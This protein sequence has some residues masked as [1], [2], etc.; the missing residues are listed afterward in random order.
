M[1]FGLVTW[2]QNLS[3]QLR[4]NLHG[5]GLGNRR[6]RRHRRQRPRTLVLEMCE[7]REV[8]SLMS[9]WQNEANLYDVNADNDVTP[10]DALIVS[11]EINSIREGTLPA[12][13]SPTADGTA[14]YVDADGDQYLTTYDYDLVAA[15]VPSSSGSGSGE[16]DSWGS[17]FG[18]DSGSGSGW[19]DDSDSG[20]GSGEDSG[21]GSG[22][23]SGDSSGSGSDPAPVLT[24]S[25]SPADVNEGDTATIFGM[26]ENVSS[27]WFECPD[28]AYSVNLE[29]I[30]G[31]WSIGDFGFGDDLPAGS[32]VDPI[33]VRIS[34]Y[35]S[36]G[37]LRTAS[38]TVTVHD[39]PPMSIVT[40]PMAVPADPGE[41]Y[42]LQIE[43]SATPPAIDEGQSVALKVEVTE[44]TCSKDYGWVTVDWGDGTSAYTS[45][46]LDFREGSMEPLVLTHQYLDDN[47]TATP[48][49]TYTITITAADQDGLSATDTRTV[50]VNNVAPAV[51]ID[52]IEVLDAV[53]STDP[54]TG[55]STY[56]NLGQLDESEGFK[57]FGTVT[58][59]GVLDEQTVTLRMD[60][61]FDGYTDDSQETV[62]PAVTPHPYAPGRWTFEY[63]VGEV[64]DDGAT[65]DAAGN[66]VWGNETAFDN[67]TVHAEVID[68]DTGTGPDER[69]VT[70]YNVLP[71]FLEPGPELSYVFDEDAFLLGIAVHG[72]VTDHGVNDE[73]RVTVFWGDGITQ[74]VPLDSTGGFHAERN[75]TSEQDILAYELGP[76][77]VYAED[78]DT[79]VVMVRLEVP[80]VN[81]TI[82]DGQNGPG[83]PEKGPNSEVARGAVTVG[84]LNDSDGD[85][86]S[87]VADTVVDGALFTHKEVD[88]MKLEIDKPVPYDPTN[89]AVLT[90][91]GSAK[92]WSEST[93]ATELD[94]ASEPIEWQP[95]ET[96]KVV[97][98]EAV[99]PST[100]LRDIG[101]QLKYDGVLDIVKAT[102]V[103][104]RR[105]AYEASVKSAAD[106]LS[107]PRFSPIQTELPHAGVATILAQL[108]GT[109]LTPIT[110]EHVSNAILFRFTVEPPGVAKLSGV[111]F[112]VTRRKEQRTWF[113]GPD[114]TV[115]TSEFYP[116][117][118]DFPAWH[119]DAA[120]D[121]TPEAGEVDESFYPD[122]RDDMFS[123]DGPGVNGVPQ[124]RE[125][126]VVR[127]LNFQEFVRVRFDG[128]DPAGGEVSGLLDGSRCSIFT[129]WHARIRLNN[130]NGNWV[131]STGDDHET[132]ENDIGLGH[133][134]VGAGP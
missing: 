71:T 115:L 108:D 128:T 94:L 84:N 5:R 25:A 118:I 129:D 126:T 3:G 109:G 31:T 80:Q 65:S 88:L 41:S 79:E 70:V 43:N 51:T 23:D 9:A 53:L 26:A 10:L 57:I 104:A 91:S 121:D 127:R 112:D 98:V 63:V 106:V 17:G 16:G 125:Q 132:D 67:L 111:R 68:D 40:G 49:D 20:S 7:R 123:I 27:L 11:N 66:R 45:P 48:S 90:V 83:L 97:W 34:G 2:L 55:V 75:F 119:P 101:I 124:P 37:T 61:N 131:R 96:S 42:E 76:V 62:Q 107:D 85:G 82:H 87:D 6:R 114:G 58:D 54:V 74:T 59:V 95:D 33:T 77:D 52:R 39:L 110:P 100:S 4:S 46:Q 105:T 89:P 134:A 81:L 72:S 35:A 13:Y 116:N 113:L 44:G 14:R 28:Y 47:P 120:N 50:I 36:D 38:T 117:P 92:F 73:H 21:S 60:L 1:R 29:A 122:N 102:G 86:V 78:D 8:L 22:S 93:K 64:L 99:G 18:D 103:W 24:I 12:A 69:D 19:G 133:R 56:L 15:A 32:A 130:V 30:N